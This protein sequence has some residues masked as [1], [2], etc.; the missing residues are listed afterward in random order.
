MVLASLRA[1]GQNLVLFI[2]ISL[3][4]A[5]GASAQDVVVGTIDKVDTGAKTVT[6]KAADGTVT[7]VKYTDKT[8]VHGLAGTAHAA[9]L[10]GKVGGRV[11]VHDVPE[12]TDKAARSIVFV[13]D[14]T[15]DKTEGTIFRIGKN[16]KTVSVKMAD[17]TVKVFTVSSHATVNA[18][19]DV[20]HYSAVSMKEGD[21]V[22]VYS[23][24][25]AGK[26][27]AHAFEHL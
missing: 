25:E 2:A 24:D 23:T 4:F 15:V 17:N 19:K 13:G 1:I 12:G 14:K 6:V 9:D 3:A 10:A 11:I 5:V 20:F 8:A 22:V 21:H 16:S 26:S 18:G 27:V 7:T